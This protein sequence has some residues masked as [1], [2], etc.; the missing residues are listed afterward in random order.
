MTM[1]PTG[2]LSAARHELDDLLASG[3]ATLT[4]A[5]AWRALALTARLAL[6]PDDVGLR[7]EP[8]RALVE[9]WLGAC[10]APDQVELCDALGDALAGDDPPEGSV[11]DV[12]LDID[13]HGGVSALRD[14]GDSVRLLLDDARATLSLFP[15]RVVPLA[16]FARMRLATL[17][18]R[19]DL[20]GLWTHVEAALV[21]AAVATQSIR[22][23]VAPA[24]VA[25]RE[26][27]ARAS[28][29][30]VTLAA[31]RLPL[32]APVALAAASSKVEMRRLGTTADEIDGWV[33]EQDGDQRIELVVADR[34][35]PVRGLVLVGHDGETEHVRVSL[36]TKREG[37]G[38][39]ASL[40]PAFGPGNEMRAGAARLGLD[41]SRLDWWIEVEDGD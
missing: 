17:D 14:D 40:G 37:R 27:L 5:D 34:S 31:R 20:R 4:D 30:V 2:W 1:D 23:P 19:A 8:D 24:A 22:T 11:L 21:N 10:A 25:A 6:A 13:D 41:A 9:A 7:A 39:F 15:E 16:G 28:R 26:H 36:P 18:P 12:L 33:Y 38:V 3:G 35:R 32:P 29:K